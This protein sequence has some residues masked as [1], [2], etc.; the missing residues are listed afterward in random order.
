MGSHGPLGDAIRDW[1]A[2]SGVDPATLVAGTK[3]GVSEAAWAEK[4]AFR[5]P[6]Y[7]THESVF[8]VL[9]LLVV[10]HIVGV[11]RGETTG[12]TPLVSAMITGRKRLP[13]PAAVM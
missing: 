8:Y 6:F 11:V 9:A 10:I 2:A 13:G 7:I 4:R 3:T 12:H 1:V 5:Y